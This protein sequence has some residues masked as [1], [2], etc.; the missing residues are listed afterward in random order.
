MRGSCRE[1]PTGS[2]AAYRLPPA[3][4]ARPARDKAAA[5]YAVSSRFAACLAQSIRRIH[6]SPG[7]P[8]VIT[9]RRIPAADAW[10]N[11]STSR[12]PPLISLILLQYCHISNPLFGFREV[13]VYCKLTLSA[14]G[15]IQLSRSAS[16]GINRSVVNFIETG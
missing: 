16:A 9:S 13:R 4:N 10:D 5:P 8:P 2:S 11:V 1:L 3:G 15:V 12:V 7:S 14:C 6:I